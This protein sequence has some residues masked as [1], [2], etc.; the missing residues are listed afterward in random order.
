VTPC[1]KKKKKEIL[2]SGVRSRLI[3]GV[4]IQTDSE[5]WRAEARSVVNAWQL[6]VRGLLCGQH[7]R[8]AVVF[9]C[10]GWFSECELARIMAV[11]S[12]AV[13]YTLSTN[14]FDVHHRYRPFLLSLTTLQDFYQP[15]V[16]PYLVSFPVS[17]ERRKCVR[18]RLL[19]FAMSPHLCDPNSLFQAF[20]W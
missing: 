10:R 14:T 8:V 12:L 1:P 3:D 6:Y 18:L 13:L 19:F 2:L 9:D 11:S 7:K 16:S 17:S 15:W 4:P 5:C 20:S